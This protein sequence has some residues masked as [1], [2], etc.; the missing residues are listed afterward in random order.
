M[1]AFEED[2]GTVGLV[3]REEEA[4]ADWAGASTPRG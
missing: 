4:V 3:L 2:E 1:S